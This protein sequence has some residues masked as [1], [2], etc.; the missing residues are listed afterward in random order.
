MTR[1]APAPVPEPDDDMHDPKDRA[2]PFPLGDYLT[3]CDPC[4]GA[5]SQQPCLRKDFERAD[6]DALRSQKAF[7]RIVR[8]AAVL[9]VLALLIGLAQRLWG[10]HAPGLWIEVELVYT[11]IA[12]VFVLAA[13]LSGKHEHWLSERFRA[14]QLRLLKFKHLIDPT[15]WDRAL[16]DLSPWKNRIATGQRAIA[17]Q[18]DDLLDAL[19]VSDTI[20]DLPATEDCFAVDVP[21]LQRLLEYYRR[22]RLDAQLQYFEG[23]MH[24]KM[25][26][27]NPRLPPV[28]FFV[29]IALVLLSDILELV[30]KHTLEPGLAWLSLAA[31]LLAFA[32]PMGW[33]AI[34][35]IRGAFE[36]S[37]NAARSHA[38]HAA[39]AEISRSLDAATAQPP[40]RWDRPMIFGYLHLCEGILGSDQ[41]EW[42]RLMK[43]AEWHG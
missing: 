41:H 15:L 17:N 30:T 37:R 18:T 3:L 43:D 9:G 24:R 5:A 4:A 33:N 38:R 1:V 21:A 31:V 7:Q 6:G 11:L 32:V 40:E 29:G 12:L 23:K 19:K 2:A 20:P 28:F 34:R 16:R 27:A 26:I 39:L 14:E 10:A 42:I 22:K 13:M 35:T 36:F 8:L 25:A